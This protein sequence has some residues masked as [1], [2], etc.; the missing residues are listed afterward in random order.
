MVLRLKNY[1]LQVS[2]CNKGYKAGI[3][4]IKILDLKELTTRKASQPHKII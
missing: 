4:K 2:Q 3:R 1:L